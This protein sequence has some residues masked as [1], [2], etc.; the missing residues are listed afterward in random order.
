MRSYSSISR[1]I[2][3]GVRVPTDERLLAH[4]FNLDGCCPD[5]G[6]PGVVGSLDP[7][8]WESH[9][10]LCPGWNPEIAEGFGFDEEERREILRREGMEG[11]TKGIL[12]GIEGAS[13]RVLRRQRR[14]KY[15]RR[16]REDRE[17]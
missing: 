5:C 12:K 9:K 14:E 4:E 16:R 3:L 1:D 2:L 15:L 11:S 8:V 17:S 7:D 6:T 10:L 13:N